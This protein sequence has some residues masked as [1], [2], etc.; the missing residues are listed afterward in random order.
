MRHVVFFLY[1]AH[2]G[3]WHGC[4]E[5]REHCFGTLND[6]VWH[7]SELRNLNTVAVVCAAAHDL[8]QE[9]DVV[10][11]FFDRNVVVFYTVNQFLEHS[12]L[13]IVG[14]KQG[15]RTDAALVR[16]ILDHRTGNAHAVIGRG[17]T[18]DLIENQQAVAGSVFE[19]VRHLT[20]LDHK[21]RLA[22]CQIV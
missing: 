11:A 7:A 22:A 5:I 13:V 10:T 16:H 17:T 6:R 2:F 3:L 21:G 8:A 9:G 18:A 12:Q 20:H 1:R 4:L 14:C 19:D 15:A